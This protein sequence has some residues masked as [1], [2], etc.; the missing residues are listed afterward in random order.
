MSP[1]HPLEEGS[2]G[3]SCHLRRSGGGAAGS[4]FA[5]APTVEQVNRALKQGFRRIGV[6]ALPCQATALRKMTLP[7]PEDAAAGEEAEVGGIA[8][9]LGL[10]CT[11]SLTQRGWL[12]LLRSADCDWPPRR[13]DIPPPPAAVME[14]DTP[15]GRRVSI[16]LDT[17]R[18]QIRAACR[19]CTDM[20]SENA[21][22]SV[23]L[24]EGVEGWNT[25]LVRTDLGADWLGKARQ[26]GVLETATLDRERLA[27]LGEA[28]VLKKRRAIGEAESLE[29]GSVPAGAALPFLGRLRALGQELDESEVENHAR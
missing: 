9:I 5:V 16:P 17:V 10:F 11:W 4:K 12:A 8:L 27:H 14:I 20:T 25:V 26:A 24:V 1:C 22:L 21:D 7:S 3:P 2:L 13:V 23:G 19:L 6:V 29:T 28:S 18:G 15:D